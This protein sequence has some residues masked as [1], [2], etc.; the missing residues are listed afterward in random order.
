[1]SDVPYTGQSPANPV[2]TAPVGGVSTADITRL[3][4]AAQAT[5]QAINNLN[6]TLSSI[7]PAG[8]TLASTAGSSSG[9]Y[10]VLVVE[11]TTYKVA[12][13]DP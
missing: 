12:L 6:Q 2:G 8:N 13:L 5:T 10:L 11:G 3:I 7:F 4:N 1:M 9:K